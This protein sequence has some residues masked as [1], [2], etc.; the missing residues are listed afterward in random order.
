M[1]GNAFIIGQCT[2]FNFVQVLT[3]NLKLNNTIIGSTGKGFG[4]NNY[5]ESAIS[6]AVAKLQNGDVLE[7]AGTADSG[8]NYATYL[9]IIKV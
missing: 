6:F 5:A 8:Y 4:S 2:Y 9:A 1:V 3:M 7:T